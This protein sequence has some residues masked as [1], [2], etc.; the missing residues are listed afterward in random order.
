MHGIGEKTAE[1]L[2]DIHIQTIEQLAKGNET[3]HSR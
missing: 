3:Y 1:K 2:K